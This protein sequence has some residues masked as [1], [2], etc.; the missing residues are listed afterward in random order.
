MTSLVSFSQ[1][2][3]LY[4]SNRTPEYHQVIEFYQHLD[5]LYENA[6]L[7]TCGPT[8]SGYP[9]HLFVI[10]RDKDF[11][12]VAARKKGKAIVLLNNGIHP[13]EPDGIDACIN[14]ANDILTKGK[15]ADDLR[16][17]VLCIIPVYNI[18]GCLNR[19]STSRVNQDG[20]ESFGFR[21][22]AQN[23]DLNRDFIKCDALNAQSFTEIFRTWDPDLF[24]DTHV[25]N[26]AD[27]QYTM[28]LI[29]TQHSKL[30]PPLG[31]YLKATMLPALYAGMEKEGFPMCPYVNEIDRIP[32]NGIAEFLETGRYSTGYT[33]LFNTIG[34]MPET[35][36][37]KPYPQRVES[38]YDFIKVSLAFVHAHKN[39][40]LD[41]RE[42]AKQYTASSKEFAINWE[43]D[44]V[45]YEN[46]LF[47]GYEAKYKPSEV[48]GLDRLYYDRNAPYEKDIRF[49]NQY[50]PSLIVQAPEA[51]IIPQSWRN[52]IQRLQLNRIAME[53]LEKDTVM[54]AEIYYIEDFHNRDAF[55]GHYLHSVVTMRKEMQKMQFHKGDYLIRMNQEANNYLIQ[56]L[57]PQAP[58][59]FFAW[60][61]FDGILMQKEYFSDYVFEDIA[62]ELLKENPQLK[63]MLDEKKKSDPDFAKDADAQ[64]NFVY[65][66]SKY[67]EPSYRRY[68]VARILK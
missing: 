68:P 16:D 47:R 49:Y 58:D 26:G 67:M 7:L 59:S 12:P 54:E 14:L 24:I 20:P 35:H 50:N 63:K 8:D 57:E 13:G 38:T 62:A 40:L 15:Y 9:L 60:G 53:R 42:K 22:N 61:F 37:L 64:L 41:V 48:S 43:M 29:A 1:V 39:E 27:Y 31:D 66:H 5:S 10:D 30:L 19:N 4:K 45:H 33:S 65:T 28:T 25:S 51:Y 55:E 52:V 56:T 32:D 44:T 6:K 21:G 46:F 18:D 11:D 17:V 36:M 2:I 34:F 3:D 23:Y